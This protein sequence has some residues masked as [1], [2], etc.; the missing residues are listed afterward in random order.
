MMAPLSKWRHSGFHVFRGNRISPNG[1]TA[2]ENLARYLI[3]AYFS[4]E[5]RHYLNQ[6]G[7]VVYTSKDG[8]AN[9]ISPA[10]ER[11]CSHSLKGN[12]RDCAS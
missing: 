5:R 12:R 1:E 8:E 9:R 3:R 10:L 4:P 2:M 6:G 7:K 11:R